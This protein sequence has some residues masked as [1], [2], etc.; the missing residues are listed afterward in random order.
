M[1][2]IRDINDKSMQYKCLAN[3]E[4]LSEPASLGGVS[5]KIEIHEKRK[6]EPKP[7]ENA[8]DEFLSFQPSNIMNFSHC[9]I[10]NAKHILKNLIKINGFIIYELPIH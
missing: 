6:L 1:M 9:F 3:L 5:W 7:T 2:D 4:S 10:F 8:I